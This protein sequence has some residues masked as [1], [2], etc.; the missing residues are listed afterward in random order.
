[1]TVRYWL[2]PPSN[3]ESTLDSS[4]CH[5]QRSLVRLIAANEA[6]HMNKDTSW[7]ANIVWQFIIS[8]APP[9][10]RQRLSALKSI[11]SN[12]NSLY[13]PTFAPLIL[14]LRY[15]NQH[16]QTSILLACYWP[17]LEREFILWSEVQNYNFK[18]INKGPFPSFL[19]WIKRCLTRVRQNKVEISKTTL[20]V[21]DK[22]EETWHSI[23]DCT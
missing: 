6:A 2:K 11:R 9:L 1:M 19:D 12:A 21:N 23:N 18:C 10:F 20:R 3:F 8:Q 15:P 13:S 17:T 4:S 5:F 7:N 22:M 16:T 14:Q